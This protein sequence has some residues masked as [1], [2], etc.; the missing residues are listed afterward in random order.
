MLTH[1]HCMA[2]ALEAYSAAAQLA[3]LWPEELWQ[4]A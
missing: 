4:L 2:E 3:C 1:V